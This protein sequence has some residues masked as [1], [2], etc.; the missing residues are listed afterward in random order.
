VRLR[1]RTIVLRQKKAIYKTNSFYPDY[2][3]V[4]YENSKVLCYP[5]SQWTIIDLLKKLTA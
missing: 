1:K 4:D 5:K 3:A 2:K